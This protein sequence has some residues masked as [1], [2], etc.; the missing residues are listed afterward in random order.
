MAG[1]KKPL[2]RTHY[3]YIVDDIIAYESGEMSDD[4][5]VAF[6][7]RLVDSGMAWQLQGSYGRM[8][9][10]LIDAGAVTRK[11]TVNDETARG[12]YSEA[13]AEDFA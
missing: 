11:G 5:I 8:A 10:S 4:Q 7:Q 1:S 3:P 12:L 6:F 2:D 9:Q 13:N